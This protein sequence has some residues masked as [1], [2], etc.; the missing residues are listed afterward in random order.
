[1][2]KTELVAL[3]SE[4]A[5]ISKIVATHAVE[6]VFDGIAGSLKDGI[7][8][9]IFGFGSFKCTQRAARTGRNPRTGEAVRISPKKSLKFSASKTLKDDL[10]PK[11]K[12]ALSKKSKQ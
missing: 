12:P 2:N 4:K 11:K 10:N 6:A 7:D 3:V 9:A 8:V 5:D 1:L